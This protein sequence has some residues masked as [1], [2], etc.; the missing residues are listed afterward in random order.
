MKAQEL[1]H[2]LFPTQA[3]PDIEIGSLTE[4]SCLADSR[5]VFVCIC[6]AH[7]DGHRFAPDAYRRGCR[8][9]VAQKELALP[10]NAWVFR[11]PDTR[12]ALAVLAANFYGEPSKKMHLIGITG[13][14]GKT[15][16]AQLLSHILNQTGIACGYIGTNGICYGRVQKSTA[17]T[18]P[19]AVTLQKNLREMLTS[20]IKTAVIEV[21]SQALLQHRVAGTHFESVVFTNLFRDHIGTNEHPDFDN[22]KSCKHRLF[23]DFGA[24]NFICNIEDPA[25]AEMLDGTSAEQIISCSMCRDG[26]DFYADRLQLFNDEKSFGIFFMLQSGQ[27]SV[28]CKL[29]LTGKVNAANAL[30]A[31]AVANRVFDIPLDSIAHTLADA[32][33]AGRSEVIP[34]PNG[35]RAVI[36]YAHNGESLAQL[37][38]TLREYSP[39]RLI[40]LFG[41]VGERSQ[42]RREELGTVA[43]K[44]S[45]LA[46]LTSDNP[47]NEAPEVIIAEIAKAFVGASTPYLCIPDRAEA[48]RAAVDLTKKGDILVLAGKGHEDYQ[49]IGNKKL[50]F[51]EK[52]ILLEAAKKQSI[53]PL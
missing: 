24:K 25:A 26:A 13:T 32:A 8:I 5:A 20:G 27:T 51:C 52:E 30:L 21:S 7:S 16:T 19:D 42:M 17:N 38:I 12:Q 29:P 40:V 45:D 35:A 28:P 4:N 39:A 14:K 15:T 46:I 33:V 2:G 6:G 48:I 43:A 10:D 22:Y 47:G 3:I 49:L 37:L 9:F 50:S 53:Y 18:T 34:L 44:H 31:A 41:S 11:C 1:L 36:D 23:T